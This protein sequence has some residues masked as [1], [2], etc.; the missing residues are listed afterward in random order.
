M[1][2]RSRMVISTTWGS[3]Q[4]PEYQQEEAMERKCP[5]ESPYDDTWGRNGCHG[6]EKGRHPEEKSQNNQE[7]VA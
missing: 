1:S 2:F 7:I 5:T 4:P 3:D 6:N